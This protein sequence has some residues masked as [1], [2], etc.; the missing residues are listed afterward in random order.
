MDIAQVITSQ[1]LASLE[2]LKQAIVKCPEMLWDEPDE[3]R[4]FWH[5][6][7]HALFYA[8]LYLQPTEKDF[9]PWAKGLPEGEPYDR[10]TVLEYLAFVQAQVMECVP[11]LDPEAAS[12]FFWLPFGKLELQFYNIRHIQQHTGEL[13]ERLGSRA[14]VELNWV[15]MK[16]Q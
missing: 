3:P 15:S 2:M 4:K 11:R 8:H 12:G 9:R 13:M 7:H 10:E 6:A 5:I 1:Y 14:G 16:P